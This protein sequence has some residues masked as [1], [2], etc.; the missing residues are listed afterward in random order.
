MAEV[1]VGDLQVDEVG[2]ARLDHLGGSSRL[3]AL[4]TRVGTPNPSSG[5]QAAR[6]SA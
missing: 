2:T 6:K 5:S 3:T 1:V 4:T